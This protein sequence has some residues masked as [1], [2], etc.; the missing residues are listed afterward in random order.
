MHW[1]DLVIIAV[2]VLSALISFMRGFVREAL[3]LLVWVAAIALG[4]RF[5]PQAVP[6]VEENLPFLAKDESI[7]KFAAGA[8]VFVGALVILGI[9]SYLISNLLIRKPLGIGDRLLALIPGI[10]RGILLVGIMGLIAIVLGFDDRPKDL[11]ADEQH[12][13]EASQLWPQTAELSQ[14]L[15]KVGEEFI[16]DLQAEEP[17]KETTLDIDLTSDADN[18]GSDSR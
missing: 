9:L 15:L 16:N 4:Y 3:S 13:S 18:G 11:S 8:I 1:V 2:V 14:W 10:G 6:F 17:T 7:L 5:F 12:W